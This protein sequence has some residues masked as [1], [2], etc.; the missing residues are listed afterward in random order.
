MIIKKRYNHV[1]RQNETLGQNANS[2]VVEMRIGNDESFDG[3][4]WQ[5][6]APK[7]SWVLEPQDGQ[8]T[9]FVQYRD[10]A[11]NVSPT[12][13]DAS[14]RVVAS[15]DI[16]SVNGAVLLEGVGAHAGIVVQVVGRSGAAP[17]F[18]GASGKYRLLLDPGTYDLM[19]SYTGY[20]PVVLEE[21]S[22]ALG[23]VTTLPPV[24]LTAIPDADADGDGVGDSAD[25]CTLVENAD[26]RDT[27]G[28]GFGNACDAD[29][30]DN[31][32]TNFS[33]LGYF[34]SV[35]F[36]GDA[37]ADFDGDGSVGFAD[38]GTFKSLFML[39]PGPSGMADA[40]AE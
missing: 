20:E 30:D 11:G 16:G 36:T 17:A 15:P 2:D 24:T 26:Q 34:K 5:P 10:A 8:A 25:N 1:T 32:A 40:C 27:N 39:P 31:C 18:T 22:V 23:D 28:D 4:L 3:V 6:Y 14:V 7:V 38:L 37:D 21:V 33:D 13:Y 29:F 12:V 35:F 19:L 9:V